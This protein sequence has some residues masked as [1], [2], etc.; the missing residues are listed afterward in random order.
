[1]NILIRKFINISDESI[2]DELVYLPSSFN[3]EL[4]VLEGKISQESNFI[5]II[6]RQIALQIYKTIE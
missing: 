1:L 5:E 6:G 3:I 4:N 2:L